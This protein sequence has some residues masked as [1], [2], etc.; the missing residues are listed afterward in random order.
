MD[1]IPGVG[2]VRRKALMRHF[3]SI[4]EIKNASV[5]Q[6]CEIPEISAN[7]AEEI[8]TFFHK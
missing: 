8:H 7:A 2:P 4:D 3:K 6:L 1:K 5:E